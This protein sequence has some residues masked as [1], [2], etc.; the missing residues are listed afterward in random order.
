MFSSKKYHA[1]KVNPAECF[2]C[3]HCMKSCPTE[4]IR[5]IDGLAVITDDKC[6]D[7]GNCMR[8]CPS[9]AFYILQDDLS[10]LN[11]FKYRVALFPSVM[12]GQFPDKISDDQ[13]YGALM[14]MGF[15]HVFEV[16]QPIQWLVDAYR[17]YQSQNRESG[18]LISAFCPAIVRLIQI[19]YP[20]L[21]DHILMVKAPHDLAAH[22][23]ISRLK[24]EKAEENEI[25]IF[26][27]APCSAKI[28]AVKRP[29]GEEKSIV[30][31]I[32]NMNE[33]YNRVMKII[34]A[35]PDNY[36]TGFREHITREG[37]L[38]SLPRGEA[39]L[40]KRKSM[41]IDGIHNVVKILEKLETETIP[42]IDFLELRS[43]DQGCAG[44]ILLSGN[45]FL[46]VERLERRARNYPHSWENCPEMPERASIME[47]MKVDPIE[48]ARVFMLD[49][50]RAK[51]VEKISEADRIISL[52]PGLDCG[53]CGAPCC[54][55]LAEDMVMGKAKMTDCIYI[56]MRLQ[57]DRKVASGKAFKS[58]EKIWGNGRFDPGRNTKK[59]IK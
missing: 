17:D 15:T 18:P 9:D 19:R 32:I 24:A 59:E 49:K 3:T 29:L 25:G 52:L 31:G 34:S 50:D 36:F 5:I 28:A 45:R 56:L 1:I 37:I 14:E 16:E 20:S 33:L 7:C 6:V 58:V 11:Q 42:E 27:I 57:K 10:L 39:R 2:G 54:R 38:W 12:I 41:A 40:F 21:I 47:R 53:A 30:S 48:P 55:A 23:A 35:R 4:A 13:I 22:F 51:A 46:T 8:A 26:Y 44:G 43:C